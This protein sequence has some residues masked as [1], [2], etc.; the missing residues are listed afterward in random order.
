[1][2]QT[3]LFTV[4]KGLKIQ[5]KV[6]ENSIEKHLNLEPI[7]SHKGS[8]TWFLFLAPLKSTP[9]PSF[10]V[11]WKVWLIF[12]HLH[13]LYLHLHLLFM[14]HG[15][16]DLS[17]YICTSYIYIYISLY[18]L[19]KILKSNYRKRHPMMLSWPRSSICWAWDEAWTCIWAWAFSIMG[20]GLFHQYIRSSTSKTF[21][22][23]PKPKSTRVLK[24]KLHAWYV[25]ACTLTMDIL[26]P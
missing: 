26:D 4:F 2:S 25:E 22:I 23:T 3:L 14:S 20:L 9:T 1:M 24:N 17:L 11:T 6:E 7:P 15:R 13:L 21:S 5:M 8:V 10:Y 19:L 12:I 18:V 16:C